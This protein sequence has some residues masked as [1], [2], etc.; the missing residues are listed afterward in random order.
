M[1]EVLNWVKY[2]GDLIILFKLGV[3]D[4][5]WFM[6]SIFFIECEYKFFKLLFDLVFKDIV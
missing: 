1:E 3:V 4:N 2:I 5:C 6:L